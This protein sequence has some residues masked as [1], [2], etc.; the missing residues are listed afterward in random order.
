MFPSTPDCSIRDVVFE[1]M[2]CKIRNVLRTSHCT[3]GNPGKVASTSEKKKLHYS[4]VHQYLFMNI[5]EVVFGGVMYANIFR[6]LS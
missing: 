6:Q 2:Y 5:C 1:D 3:D 4:N